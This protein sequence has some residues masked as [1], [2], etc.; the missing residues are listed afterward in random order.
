MKRRDK[1]IAACFAFLVL[2]WIISYATEP[3]RKEKIKE[4][5]LKFSETK[6]AED[7]VKLAKMLETQ[8]TQSG[9]SCTAIPDGR[10]LRINLKLPEGT[11]DVAISS[12]CNLMADSIGNFFNELYVK[13]HKSFINVHFY[14]KK[15]GGDVPTEFTYSGLGQKWVDPVVS[16]NRFNSALKLLIEKER[17][18]EKEASVWDREDFRN[19]VMF[20]TPEQ[21]IQAVGQPTSTQNTGGDDIW[22]YDNSTKDPT[23]GKVYRITQVCFSLSRHGMGPPAV[24]RVNFM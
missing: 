9:F 12:F 10:E 16:K 17:E 14:C 20:K 23:T 19:A 3:K 21:V 7:V 13:D 15:T 24:S 4:G 1:I 5:D 22:Y 8:A 6:L 11:N 2:L 18:K